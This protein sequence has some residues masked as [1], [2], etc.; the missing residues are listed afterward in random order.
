MAA[1]AQEEQARNTVEGPVFSL[2]EGS[3][4]ARRCTV[5]EM[6]SQ[7]VPITRLKDAFST[8]SSPI[9]LMLSDQSHQ[10]PGRNEVTISM[11]LTR[12]LP[13]SRLGEVFI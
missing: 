7:A 10:W 4:T 3:A 13:S 9:I 2:I 8:A 5:P 6:H 1:D 12:Q 11:D